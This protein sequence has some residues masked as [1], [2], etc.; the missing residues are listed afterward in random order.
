[1]MYILDS[2]WF[3]LLN[4]I[5]YS[6]SISYKIFN[7]ILPSWWQ[8]GITKSH[9]VST[10]TKR[11][12]VSAG[13]AGSFDE[14]ASVDNSILLPLSSIIHVGRNLRKILQK[15]NKK[16][17][18]IPLRMHLK[19]TANTDSTKEFQVIHQTSWSNQMH[20]FFLVS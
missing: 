1:M 7:D 20:V 9:H 5:S 3:L 16:S 12:R 6:F 10:I 4:I 19:T 14:V 11:S 15:K 17:M 18:N 8:A 13:K 2:V